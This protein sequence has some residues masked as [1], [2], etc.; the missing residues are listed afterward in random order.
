[1][2]KDMQKEVKN[3]EKPNNEDFVPKK[4]SVESIRQWVSWDVSRVYTIELLLSYIS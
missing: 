4:K 3:L 2:D 1:M